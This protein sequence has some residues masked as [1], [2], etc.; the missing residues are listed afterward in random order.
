MA[1]PGF[2]RYTNPDTWKFPGGWQYQP[3]Q[4]AAARTAMPANSTQDQGGVSPFDSILTG[5]QN[6][7]DL[8]YGNTVAAIGMQQPII[9]RSY[10][11]NDDGSVDPNNPFSKAQLLQRSYQQTKTGTGNQYA[12]RGQLYSGAL[13]R[14]QNENQFNFQAQDAQLRGSYAQQLAEL[15]RMRADAQNS[16]NNSYNDAFT[17]WLMRQ[18]EQ[19]AAPPVDPNGG[20]QGDPTTTPPGVPNQFDPFD[21][22]IPAVGPQIPLD[23]PPDY[24]N[25]RAAKGASSLGSMLGKI[26]SRRR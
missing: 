7:A 4:Q 3:Q 15:A 9:Q 8:N 12:A 5:A 23:L 16:K 24:T 11:Y 1:H 22:T 21:P 18:I 6:T 25:R 19:R 2:L 17:G 20:G 26:L 10:G 13:Q 14:Q